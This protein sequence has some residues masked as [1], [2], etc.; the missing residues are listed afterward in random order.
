MKILA[1]DFD[2]V[3]CDSSREI[4]LV[5]L[6]TCA[7]LD[8]DLDAAEYLDRLQARSGDRD[9]FAADPVY[10]AFVALFPLGNGAEDF[11]VA[12]KAVMSGLALPDQ[13]AYDRYFRQQNAGW[14]DAFH[15]AFYDQRAALRAEDE[16][17]WLALHGTWPA[18]TSLLKDRAGAVPYAV[19][20]AKD[21]V[22]V[23]KLLAHFGIGDLFSVDLILDKETGA[24]KIAHLTEL[25]RRTGVDP[26]EITFVDDKVSHLQKVAPLGVRCVL[27]AWGDN[28]SREH[29]QA[30]QEGFPVAGLERVEEILFS[31]FTESD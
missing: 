29:L 5:T 11:A 10:T 3:I 1:L 22:S 7:A 8:S 23:Q 21:A 28:G 17:R 27:A 30:R 15:R 13:A 18:V 9:D 25:A 2:G 26:A 16:A 20:T 19:C 24:Q 6:R 12:L 4:F 31:G 14:K